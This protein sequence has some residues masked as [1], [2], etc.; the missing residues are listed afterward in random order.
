MGTYAVKLYKMC[1]G[2]LQT[3]QTNSFKLTTVIKHQNMC[4]TFHNAT[5]FALTSIQFGAV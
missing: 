4:I 3:Q 1:I 2:P 5:G